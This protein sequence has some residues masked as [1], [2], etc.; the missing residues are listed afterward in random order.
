MNYDIFSCRANYKGRISK[1]KPKK[2]LANKNLLIQIYNRYLPLPLQFSIPTPTVIVRSKLAKA[3]LF[4]ESLLER[5]D[6]WFFY[7]L[8][9]NGANLIQIEDV[10]VT[11]KPRSKKDVSKVTLESEIEWFSRLEK[12]DKHLG[13]KFILSVALRNR[14]IIGKLVD[15][16][17]ILVLAYRYQV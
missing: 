10:L 8:Q 17:K 6:L 4:D 15:A 13:W 11:V 9:S 14:I 1:L 16:T 2:I 5:E 7:T 12:I 3:F